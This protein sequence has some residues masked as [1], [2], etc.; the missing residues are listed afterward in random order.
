MARPYVSYD[1]VV[2]DHQQFP[3]LRIGTLIGSIEFK[4]DSDQATA[5]VWP[6]RVGPLSR[7][8]DKYSW[9]FQV[10]NLHFSP[11]RQVAVSLP[12]NRRTVRAVSVK[13][14]IRLDRQSLIQVP[15]T[16]ERVSPWL[17]LFK[18]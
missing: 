14:A 9:P 15:L 8:S 6:V 3:G 11:Y 5:L 12:Y 10:G 1:L 16:D 4:Q 18:A 2:G 7:P 17:Q 13:G